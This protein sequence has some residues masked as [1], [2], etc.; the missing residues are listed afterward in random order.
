MFP[1]LPLLANCYKI[2]PEGGCRGLAFFFYCLD[3]SSNSI[4]QQPQLFDKLCHGI[5]SLYNVRTSR[6]FVTALY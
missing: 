2:E 4:D 3:Q 1:P 5:T 6:D